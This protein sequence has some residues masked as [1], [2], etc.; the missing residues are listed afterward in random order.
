MA[1]RQV[2]TI[3]D[4]ILTKNCRYV[5][6]IDDRVCKILDD[7]AETMYAKDGVGLA[8]PQIGVLRQL[9]VLDVGEGLIELINPQIVET[10][11]EQ[12]GNEGCLSVPGKYG[13]VT[14]PMHVVVKAQNREGTWMQYEGS[15]L[16]ARC[17]CHEVDHLSGK[18]FVS[19]AKSL[20]DAEEAE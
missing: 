5:D 3:G 10:S 17:V 4:E 18:L 16:F 9:V 6:V 15:E 19:L 1:I 11:G 13:E 14:R 20:S 2:R 12:T 8:A 7:M